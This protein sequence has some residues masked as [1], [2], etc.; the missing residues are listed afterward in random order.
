MAY[1][2]EQKAL[3][4]ALVNRHGGMTNEALAAVEAAL[5][6]RISTGTLHNWL[7][8]SSPGELKRETETE[9]ETEK[10]TVGAEVSPEVQAQAEAALD[11]MF[12]GVARLYL[13]HA[14]QADVV[15]ATKGKEAVI[16]AATAVDKMRLLRN[17]PTE[18]VGLMPELISALRAANKDPVAIFQRMVQRAHEEAGQRGSD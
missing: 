9:T 15:G 16:A 5:G 11:D 10:R 18:I 6:K 4:I 2:A 7:S 13:K 3:A 14:A 17:L 1:T 12:E 8:K